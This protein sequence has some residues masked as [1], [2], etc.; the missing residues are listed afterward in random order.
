[1]PCATCHGMGYLLKVVTIDNV[2]QVTPV[3]CDCCGGYPDDC[4]NC[5]AGQRV[6]EWV[7]AIEEAN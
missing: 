7:D 4:Q 1:M 5:E 6:I 2:T 3:A